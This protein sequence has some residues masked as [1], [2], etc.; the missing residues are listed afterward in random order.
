MKYAIV[1]P[2]GAADL[3]LD[4]LDGLTPFEAADIPNLDKISLAGRQGTV[5][6][7]PPGWSAGS[8]V[9][10]M[11]LLGYNP[12]KYHT[13][14]APLEAAA[15]NIPMTGDDWIFR[16]NL[17]TVDDNGNM[18]DHSAGHIGSPEAARLLADLKD[19]A[20]EALGELV[21]RVRFIPGTS[22][23]NIV[24][25]T[26]GRDYTDVKTTPPH[27]IP[28]LPA[29]R[30]LPTGGD[31]AHVLV[32]ITNLSAEL[33]KNHEVNQA[34]RAS[35][36]RPASHAWLW[37]QGKRPE[38]PSFQERFGMRGA[39]IT[40]VDLLAGIASYTKLDRLFVPGITGLHDTDY[41][42]KGRKACEAL[43][44][45]D[46]VIAHVEAP[47]EAS[48]QSDFETKVAAIEAIDRHVIGPILE[49][50]AAFDEW[51]ILVLPDHY[52]L[53]SNR[54]H[55]ATPVPFAMAGTRVTSVVQ[56]P[57]CEKNANEA[58]L[59]IEQGHDLMEYFLFSGGAR[60]TRP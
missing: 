7:T 20:H 5:A 46:L 33:F 48:H 26:S 15:L 17:V 27:D 55:D 13:G 40:A 32:G 1:I 8:D 44:E 14:R 37:G 56:D 42:A 38:V 43:D 18:L 58:D 39:I 54:L 3:P 10:S 16:C 9:C 28:G 30:H 36:D 22:Y 24:V 47:D 25:D 34:R 59:H 4:D 60:T 2:D 29:D 23:R 53:C 19:A 31:A 12:E 51:R 11:S 52:T 35:G 6:T 49:K 57:F 45:Y 21:D 41:A 50:L